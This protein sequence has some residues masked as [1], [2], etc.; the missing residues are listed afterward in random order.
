MAA[1]LSFHHDTSS[2]QAL[3]DDDF[4]YLGK[5]GDAITLIEEERAIIFR[6]AIGP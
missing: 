4:Y 3:Q 5:M 2:A 1:G 6:A